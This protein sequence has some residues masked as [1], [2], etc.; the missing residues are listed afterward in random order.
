MNHPGGSQFEAR[1]AE[2][3]S[4]LQTLLGVCN[5][6]GIQKSAASFLAGLPSTER[7]SVEHGIRAMQAAG[8]AVKLVKRDP[9]TLPKELLPAVLI[10]KDGTAYTLINIQQSRSGPTFE[11]HEA[12]PIEKTTVLSLVELRQIYGGHC[13]LIK[14][15]PKAGEAGGEDEEEKKKSIPNGFG[16]LFGA[17]AATTT[18][19]CWRQY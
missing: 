18:I 1:P 5:R 14:Q 19:V 10:N 9:S 15:L 7:L 2:T 17:I 11:V 3:D 8:F 4:L 6:Y 13:L 12:G 16:K